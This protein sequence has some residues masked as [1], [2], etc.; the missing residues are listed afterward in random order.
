MDELRRPGRVDHGD[1]RLA[2]NDLLGRDRHT[3]YRDRG[4]TARPG[5]DILAPLRHVARVPRQNVAHGPGVRAPGGSAAGG[6]EEGVAQPQHV[7]TV[8]DFQA[9]DEPPL[10]DMQQMREPDGPSLPLDEQ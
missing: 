10:Q 2:P 6:A 8:P 5:H 3:P 1:A 7:R 9:A 4:D